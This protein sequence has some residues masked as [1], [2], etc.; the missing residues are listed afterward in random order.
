MPSELSVDLP[1]L[2]LIVRE[3][4]LRSREKYTLND[5]SVV[6]LAWAAHHRKWDV[7]MLESW[8][9]AK[10][11]AGGRLEIPRG[12]VPKPPPID[13]LSPWAFAELGLRNGV[14]PGGG[15]LDD[16]GWGEIGGHSVGPA[17]YGR[18]ARK[19]LQER[20][21]ANPNGAFAK[22]LRALEAQRRRARWLMALTSAPIAPTRGR[23]VRAVWH[24]IRR[25]RRV[26]RAHPAGGARARRGADPPEQDPEPPRFQE[27]RT[28]PH[29]RGA[30]KAAWPVRWG[31]WPRAI[32]ATSTRRP[33]R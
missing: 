28:V 3:A 9:A 23:P 29:A 27:A 18:A 31:A 11:R 16:R 10:G 2:D 24:R 17:T 20:A 7:P 1:R 25:S 15:V 13:P 30:P 19:L 4:L 22:E 26:R 6:E 5:T 14:L 8:A 12:P 21:A 33:A 32:R